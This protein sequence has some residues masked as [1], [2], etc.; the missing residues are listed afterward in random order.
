MAKRYS[1]ALLASATLIIAPAASQETADADSVRAPFAGKADPADINEARADLGRHLLFDSRLSG[2]GSRACSTCHTPETGWTTRDPLSEGYTNTPH[3]RNA[4]SLFNVAQGETLHWDSRLAGND[5]GTASRD[6]IVEAHFMNADSRIVQ[7]RLKQ[8]PEY[9]D[10]F[11]AAYGNEPYGG[12]IYGALAEYMK[13][14]R[15]QNAPFQRFLDGKDDAL[16]EEARRGLDLFVGKANCVACHSGPTLSDG[17][18][19]ALGV[20]DHPSLLTDA[21]RQITM[22]RY[23]SSFGVP[24]YMN[25]R[26]DV[27]FFA[28]SKDASDIGKFATPS[29]WDVGQTGPYMHSGVFETLSE[30]VAFYDGGGGIADNKSDRIAPLSLTRDERQALV[31][32]LESLTGDAPTETEPSLPAYAAD[33]ADA[34][35]Q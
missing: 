27:G 28:V 31:A 22:L 14:I 5:L 25:R 10:M 35:A 32:F 30:V 17:E 7:E 15:T 19:H 12:R 2:D 18:V 26:S 29:L 34:A 11:Q 21:G 16:S 8:V 24:N 3:F 33:L 6:G 20:P 1:L 13:T 4:P 9:V 23:Y